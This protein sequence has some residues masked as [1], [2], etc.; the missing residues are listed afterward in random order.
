V[1]EPLKALALRIAKV[2]PEPKAPAGSPGSIRIFRAASNYWKY[3]LVSWGVKQVA[4]AFAIVFFLSMTAT[5]RAAATGLERTFP[6]AIHTLE[7]VGLG[8]FLVQLPLSLIAARLNY[9]MRWYIVTDRSLRLREGIFSVREMTLTYA[10]VQNIA[11]QQGP[12]QRLLGIADVVV[13]T[14]GGGGGGTDDHGNE[15]HGA[16]ATM[17]TGTLRAVD[18]AEQVRDLILDRLRRLRDA[19]LG[20]PDDRRPRASQAGPADSAALLRAAVGELLDA[21]RALRK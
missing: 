5:W 8:L 21:A 20:D 7:L 18:N 3:L 17:H 15:R 11:I 2:P 13:R 4:A 9:E 19:G 12:L 6:N 16:G 10:N 14:A 1:F